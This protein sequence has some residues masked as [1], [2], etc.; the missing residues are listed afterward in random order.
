VNEVN[1]RGWQNKVWKTKKGLT[2]GGKAFDKC[3]IYSLLT[4]PLY[5][6]LI[7]HKDLLH[8]G[9]HENLIAPEVFEAVQKQLKQ[10]GRGKGNHLINKHGAL[11]KSLLHCSACDRAMV[12]TFTR[13]D[14]KQYRYYTCTNVIKNGRGKC[15]SPNLPAGEIEQAV[16]EQIRA[17][18]ADVEIQNQVAAQMREGQTKRLDELQTNR[19]Q[20]ERQLSR[21]HAEIGKLAVLNDPTGATS[22]RIADLHVRITKCESDLSRVVAA[23]S[24]LERSATE[25]AEIAESVLNQIPGDCPQV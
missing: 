8:K 19:R 23:V 11:L 13:K 3:S 22:A 2:R 4:N 15:P 12:H 25:K 18:G 5:A 21:D 14:E 17:I 7:R 20:L 10:N 6:G 1:K 24:E 9:E 16:I